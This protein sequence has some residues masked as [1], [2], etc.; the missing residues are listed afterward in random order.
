MNWGAWGK[1]GETVEL[2]GI[3]LEHEHPGESSGAFWNFLVATLVGS[4]CHVPGK[5]GV[6]VV[7]IDLSYIHR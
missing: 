2:A 1:N 3:E 5:L 7:L 4:G 6:I